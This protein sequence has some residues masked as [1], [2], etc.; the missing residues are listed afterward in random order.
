M[1]KIKFT[2]EKLIPGNGGKDCPHNGYGKKCACDEC[3]WFLCCFPE[4]AKNSRI[5][6]KACDTPCPRKSRAKLFCSKKGTNDII[7]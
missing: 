6:C 3:D 5:D 2:R 1:L 7:L 4:Y